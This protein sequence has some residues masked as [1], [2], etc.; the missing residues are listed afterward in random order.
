MPDKFD[1]NKIKGNMGGF[2]DSIKSMI[3][4]AGAVTNVNPSDALGMKI[5][6][7]SVLIKQMTDAQNEHVRNLNRV[8]ELLNGLFHDLEA[9]RAQTQVHPSSTPVSESVSSTQ[10]PVQ[11]APQTPVSE[12][13]IN[14][15]KE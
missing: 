2:M 1:F 6:E 8:N 12:D 11:S 10:K 15:G 14:R 13:P 9:L 3:N 7:I 5:A 4:P